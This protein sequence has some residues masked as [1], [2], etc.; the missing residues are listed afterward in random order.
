MELELQNAL[1]KNR[2]FWM[3]CKDQSAFLLYDKA[4]I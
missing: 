2:V 3:S 1:K 4:V